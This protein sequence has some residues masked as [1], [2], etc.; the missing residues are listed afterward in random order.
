M[1]RSY[2]AAGA[3]DVVEKTS[4]TCVNFPQ[5]RFSV[6]STFKMY[7]QLFSF[8]ADDHHLTQGN[9]YDVCREGL[10]D[11]LQALHKRY[12]IS[13]LDIASLNFFAFLTACQNGHL[14][15]AKWMH[16]NWALSGDEAR[17][18]GMWAFRY[19]NLSQ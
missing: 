8:R 4:A 12:K 2:V 18:Q 3:T 10:V 9:R 13:K 7:C 11:T 14:S 17:A 1:N 6:A 19:A 15:I 5:R 16:E